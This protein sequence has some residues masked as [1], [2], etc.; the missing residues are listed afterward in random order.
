MDAKSPVEFDKAHFEVQKILSLLLSRL[1][2]R[3]HAPST[4][5]DF[6]TQKDNKGTGKMGFGPQSLKGAVKKG[7][8]GSRE[9]GLKKIGSFDNGDS[10]EEG[11]GSSSFTTDV[12]LDLLI[13]L[14][15]LLLLSE[16]RGWSILSTR[17]GA[18]RIDTRLWCN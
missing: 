14:R 6:K 15:D 1:H 5:E 3:P 18:F 7:R 4:F 8:P 2:D 12:T 10:D 9:G 17:L 13:Q 16:S 11:D